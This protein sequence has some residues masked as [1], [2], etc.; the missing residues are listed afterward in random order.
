MKGRRPGIKQT[1]LVSALLKLRGQKRKKAPRERTHGDF[2]TD[3]GALCDITRACGGKRDQNWVKLGTDGT[4][5]GR[6][7][8]LHYL[9]GEGKK[10]GNYEKRK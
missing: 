6:K 7:N 4:K 5:T 1:L 3:R 2:V 8:G 9:T 10:V